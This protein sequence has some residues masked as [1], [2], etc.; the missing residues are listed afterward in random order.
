MTAAAS[1]RRRKVLAIGG[2]TDDGACVSTH[3]L[4]WSGGMLPR[5]I[6]TI[7]CSDI[8]S[9]AIVV[10]DAAKIPGPSVFGAPLAM[11]RDH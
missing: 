10:L 8:T 5:K 4:G 11:F 1:H 9:E 2:D 3:I 6:F 7:R